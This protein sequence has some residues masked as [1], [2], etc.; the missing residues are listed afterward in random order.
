[1]KDNYSV[2][3]YF[4]PRIL[5]EKIAHQSEIF[6]LLSGWVKIHEI[7]Y[8]IFGTNSHFASLFSAMKHNS[9]VFFHLN[10]ICFG[11][12]DPIKVQIFRLSTAYMKIIQI[13]YVFFE[14]TCQFFFKTCINI[15]CHDTVPHIIPHVIFETT[16]PFFFKLCITLQCLER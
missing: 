15:Q 8:V 1:M 2:F 14:A 12:K 11:Q 5:W 10:F 7:P 9:S 4:K 3:F 16:S 13:P 6:E